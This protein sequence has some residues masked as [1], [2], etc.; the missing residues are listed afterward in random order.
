MVLA[1]ASVL[2]FYRSSPQLREPRLHLHH[3]RAGAWGKRSRSVIESAFQH[4]E[5]LQVIGL[6]DL[7][8]SDGLELGSGLFPGPHQKPDLLALV[9]LSALRGRQ[10]PPSAQEQIAT[11]ASCIYDMLRC[12]LWSSPGLTG[13][14]TTS[15]ISSGTGSLRKRSKKSSPAT[16]RSGELV[17]GDI[18]PWA[19]H[20][21]EGWL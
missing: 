12:F 13:T 2:N 6:P 11:V 21:T 17:K 19:R 14:T 16:I 10:T 8:Y 20:T 4:L 5:H 7:P 1:Y 18:S 9:Q 3:P 15:S